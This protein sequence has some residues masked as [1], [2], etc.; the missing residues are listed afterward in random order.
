MT[1][2]VRLDP[3]LVASATIDPATQVLTVVPVPNA[4]G[5]TAFTVTLTD[6]G[7]ASAHASVGL[8]LRPINDAPALSITPEGDAEIY[9]DQ[10]LVLEVAAR[11]VAD[12]ADVITLTT[13][14]LPANASWATASGNPALGE[15]RFAPVVGQAGVY[16][17]RSASRTRSTSPRRR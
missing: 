13:S 7:G 1:G 5:S 11:D 15:F 10:T 3:A 8:T 14:A 9:D 4:F 16:G 12:P 2:I 17:S 6:S